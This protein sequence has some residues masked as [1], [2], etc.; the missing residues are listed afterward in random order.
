MQ[1]LTA[2]VP[3]LCRVRD[4]IHWSLDQIFQKMVAKRPEQRYQT[5][6]EVVAALEDM[7]AST[8]GLGR[9]AVATGD[10]GASDFFRQLQEEAAAPPRSGPH[11]PSTKIA[12]ETEEQTV[13]QSAPEMDIRQPKRQPY[14][15]RPSAKQENVSRRLARR[16][17]WP[18]RPAIDCRRRR[19]V[20][21]S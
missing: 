21:Q 20:A 9:L 16:R 19:H 6:D 2:P 12:S 7:Q 13:E 10:E 14:S 4:E 18:D 3:S 11:H 1:H 5:M 17:W 15:S 8:S